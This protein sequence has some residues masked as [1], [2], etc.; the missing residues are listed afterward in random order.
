MNDDWL[1]EV[2]RRLSLDE[3]RQKRVQ[4]DIRRDGASVV[5]KISDQGQGFEWSQFLEMDPSRAFDVHGRGIAMA[6]ML[7]F[8]ELNYQGIGNQVE[9]VLHLKKH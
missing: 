9:A 6:K 7:S 4:V 5:L 2:N 1:A 8:D 3:N